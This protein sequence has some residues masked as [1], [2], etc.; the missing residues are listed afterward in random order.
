[1]SRFLARGIIIVMKQYFS[2]RQFKTYIFKEGTK[3]EEQSND[4]VYTFSFKRRG[5]CL[6]TEK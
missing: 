3:M 4:F 5:L 1:M 2:W 6:V